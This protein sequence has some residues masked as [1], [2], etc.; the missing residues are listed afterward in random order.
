[1]KVIKYGFGLFIVCLIVISVATRQGPE[2]QKKPEPEVPFDR[3]TPAQHLAKAKSIMQVEDPSNLSKDQLDEATRHFRAIPDSTPESA[4]ALASQRQSLEA[5][6]KKYLE[7]VREKYANDLEA[8]LRDQGLDTVV[9]ELGDQLI[10]ASDLFND[11]SNRVQILASI[12]NKMRDSQGL[13]DLGFRR[14][15]L[16][17]SGMFSGTHIYSLGCKTRK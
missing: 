15:A 9:T 6:T 10:L 4:E 14:V 1:M 3:M 11:E 12:R 8:V 13:C 5:A 17:G 2:E 7:K 16:S